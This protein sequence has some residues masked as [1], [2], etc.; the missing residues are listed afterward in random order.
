MEFKKQFII[1]GSILAGLAAFFILG[2]VVKV[3]GAVPRGE[4]V[5]PDLKKEAVVRIDITDKTG[6]LE[7]EKGTTG[8]L[9][10][11]NGKSFE[12]AKDTAD[13]LITNFT[14]MRR[15]STAGTGRDTWA[16]FSVDDASAA[17]IT[18]YDS[19]GTVQA[20]CFFGKGGS[21]SFSQYVRLP[22]AD[23][24]IQIDSRIEKTT[25]LKDWVERRLFPDFTADDV[26]RV[27][28]NTSLIFSDKA[29]PV[30]RSLAYT[31]VQGEK[32]KD[33][34][35][36]W[37]ITEDERLPLAGA[38]VNGFISSLSRFTAENVVTSPQTTD[39]DQQHPLGSVTVTMKSGITY[40]LFLLDKAPEGTDVFYVTNQDHRNVYTAGNWALKDIFRQGVDSFID[41][42]AL[43]N[44][45]GK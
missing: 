40:T 34:G 3:S 17:K 2:T 41:A 21:T 16:A 35:N 36:T 43:L 15:A 44:L 39:L 14:D 8:W 32:D 31:L 23:E 22:G 12:A 25:L 1:Y 28:V 38:T 29:E 27:A 33:G 4:K 42:Q 6:R 30:K 7:L 5:F 10:K 9:V 18:L 20:A 11:T 19:S 26:A 45:Q 37:K 13:S 24:V